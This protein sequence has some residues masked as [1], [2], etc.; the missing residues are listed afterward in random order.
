M[1]ALTLTGPGGR[2]VR[3][4]CTLDGGDEPATCDT[5]REHT[6]DAAAYTAVAEFTRAGGA[7]PLL[8]SGVNSGVNFRVSQ[9]G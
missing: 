9:R 8:H 2:T 3:T 7:G 6:G 1:A 5:P 4:R